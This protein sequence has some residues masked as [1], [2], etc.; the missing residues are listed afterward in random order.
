LVPKHFLVAK[1]NEE[2]VLK[3]Y[4]VTKKKIPRI[5]TTDPVIKY[6]GFQK[7]RIVK[8]VR[9]DGETVYRCVF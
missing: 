7:G 4:N 2:Y 6:Y 3:K 9:R 5:L 1:E 8:V